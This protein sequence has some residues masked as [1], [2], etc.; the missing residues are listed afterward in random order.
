MTKKIHHQNSTKD[1]FVEKMEKKC[2]QS[3]PNQSINRRVRRLWGH[4]LVPLIY[5]NFSDQN[6]KIFFNLGIFLP[7]DSID[8][9]DKNE[10]E[11]PWKPLEK[12]EKSAFWIK[13][14]NHRISPSQPGHRRT[15]SSPADTLWG[16]LECPLSSEI[17]WVTKIS[18]QK[19]TRKLL[20]EDFHAKWPRRP[21][22]FIILTASLNLRSFRKHMARRR[23]T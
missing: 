16:S 6:R 17:P 19:N 7:N 23:R 15:P 4:I 5:F 20:R 10:K 1:S 22:S 14:T 18:T 12:F 9:W 8:S 21:T 13:S 3:V 2:K 11:K